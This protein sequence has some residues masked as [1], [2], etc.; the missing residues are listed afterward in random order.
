MK[1]GM[2]WKGWT[3]GDLMGEGSFG[4][5]YRIYREDYGRVYESALK[6]IRIPQSKAEENAVR[7][8]VMN[9]EDVRAYFLSSVESIIDEIS[10]MSRLRGNSNIVSYEDHSVDELSGEF[11]WRICI[12]MELLTPLLRY[13][14]MQPVTAGDVVRM[15]IDICKA[16]ETCE[17]NQII[18]RDIKPENIFHSAQGFYKLGDFGI[19]R[20]MEKSTAGMSKKG[21]Y[22]YMAPEVVRGESYD[23]TVDIYSLGV[24]LYRFLNNNRGPFLPHYPD[25]IYYDDKEK[26]NDQRLN[27]DP[28]EPPCNADAKAGEV[29]LRACSFWPEDRYQSAEEFRRALESVLTDE[30]DQRQAIP[31]QMIQP[32]REA[33]ETVTRQTQSPMGS[34]PVRKK[35]S[36]SRKR[37]IMA[38][39]AAAVVVIGLLGGM[40]LY[41]GIGKTGGAGDQGWKDAYI[42]IL[43]ENENS[44]REY[45]SVDY[46][47]AKKATALCDLNKD[48]IPELLFF[49]SKDE[50]KLMIYTY[51]NE[52]AQEVEYSYEDPIQYGDE[53]DADA[54][55][56]GFYDPQAGGG[57]RCMI[58]QEGDEG[59]VICSKLYGDGNSLRYISY[60][61]NDNGG[62][63]QETAIG[64]SYYHMDED[65]VTSFYHDGKETGQTQ[66]DQLSAEMSDQITTVLMEPGERDGEEDTD[67]LTLPDADG[68]GSVNMTYDEILAQLGDDSGEAMGNYQQ[69]INEYYRFIEYEESDELDVMM[70]MVGG[71]EYPHVSAHFAA[72]LYEMRDLDYGSMNLGYALKDIDGNGSEEMIFR[73]DEEGGQAVYGLDENDEPMLLADSDTMSV[74]QDGR[75]IDHYVKGRNMYYDEYYGSDIDDQYMIYR[76]VDDG[77]S[78]ETEE[79]MSQMYDDIEDKYFYYRNEDEIS[80]EQYRDLE[81]KIEKDTDLKPDWTDLKKKDNTWQ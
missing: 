81:E 23:H 61:M 33:K 76:F 79:V 37:W 19:A 45:E 6:V 74:K 10:F 55:M 1:K 73:W 31:D 44:I 63:T 60:T 49:S 29:I 40:V 43:K 15:G 54:V 52:A 20:Q 35:P 32:L 11:G 24:V 38:G 25:K 41:G 36:V 80:E 28:M 57:M 21:T 66:F 42:D 5:V 12:R 14:Q 7:S 53:S 46:R 75:I 26:A 8:E 51:G 9:D 34:L 2:T 22:S 64:E 59:L 70:E 77:S 13:I 78:L 72:D 27:G 69:V 67:G 17:K 50:N 71:E 4:K 30:M 39:T 16:L 62:L 56:D 18:H 68:A 58:Y 65:I 3:I 48:E 47:A